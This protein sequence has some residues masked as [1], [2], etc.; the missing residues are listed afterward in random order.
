MENGATLRVS[1]RVHPRLYPTSSVSS[2]IANVTAPAGNFVAAAKRLLAQEEPWA[3]RAEWEVLKS[4]DGWQ[5]I[6][7]RVEHPDQKGPNIVAFFLYR[8]KT[9]KELAAQAAAGDKA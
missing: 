6:A 3:E 8:P 1:T 9:D 2:A 5:V 4:R 7:W